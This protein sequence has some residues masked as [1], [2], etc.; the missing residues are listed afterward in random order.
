MI[1]GAVANH[2]VRCSAE[3]AIVGAHIMRPPVLCQTTPAL[4][5]TPLIS[6]ATTHGERPH[7]RTV[8]GYYE[9][10]ALYIIAHAG[11]RRSAGLE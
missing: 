8:N 5:A 11:Q 3:F 9:D 6:V 10:G 2:P 4:R 7:T 1:D